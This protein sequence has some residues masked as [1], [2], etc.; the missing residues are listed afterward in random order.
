MRKYGGGRWANALN[1]HLLR[2]PLSLSRYRYVVIFY[3]QEIDP[4][5]MK[6]DRNSFLPM[7]TL[8]RLS[9]FFS[10]KSLEFHN[11]I[12]FATYINMQ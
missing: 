7:G 2:K 11:H 8:K 1:G 5:S 3:R 6:F 4:Q 12:N 10:K 9:L